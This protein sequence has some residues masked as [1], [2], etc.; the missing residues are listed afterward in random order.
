MEGAEEIR[1]SPLY[2]SISWYTWGWL[3][4]A[5]ASEKGTLERL[6]S[7]CGAVEANT[8]YLVDV[9][10]NFNSIVLKPARL[11][12]GNGYV[13]YEVADLDYHE[14]TS[15]DFSKEEPGSCLTW[16]KGLFTHYG[17]LH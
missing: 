4:Q 15:K 14:R 7:F 13:T 5:G 1:F 6:N 11:Q 2:I 17:Y 8:R 12:N 3:F 9:T 10:V 16:S